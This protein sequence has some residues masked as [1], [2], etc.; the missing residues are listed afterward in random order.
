MAVRGEV[1]MYSRLIKVILPLIFCLQVLGLPTF[2]QTTEVFNKITIENTSNFLPRKRTENQ[3]WWQWT[4]F[5]RGPEAQLK[6]ISCVRYTLHRTYAE[7]IQFVC[8]RGDGDRAFEFTAIAW[9]VFKVGVALIMRKGINPPLVQLE[10]HF[11]MF[12]TAG[13]VVPF[14]PSR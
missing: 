12:E 9:G 11:L 14:K 7:P 8:N 5:L 2:G 3:N 4:I 1:I 13:D 10:A 6:Q